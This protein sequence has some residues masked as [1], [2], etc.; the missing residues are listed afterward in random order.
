MNAAIVAPVVGVGFLMIL[1]IG[2]YI[3]RVLLKGSVFL[4][5]ILSCVKFSNE[6]LKISFLFSVRIFCTCYNGDVHILIVNCFILYNV[7]GK[8][9]NPTKQYGSQ[10]EDLE[11]PLFDLCTITTATNN[12]SK[13][14]MLGQGGF[15]SVYRVS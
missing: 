10:E 3:W 1:V 14:N 11:L 15:G 13:S 6:H 7:T 5:L 2:N 9:V 4:T 12:F 8:H